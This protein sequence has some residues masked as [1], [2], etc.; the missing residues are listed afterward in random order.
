[1]DPRAAVALPPLMGFQAQTN[2]KQAK[3][4]RQQEKSG[5]TDLQSLQTLYQ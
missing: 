2:H 4:C 5:K 1:M 3:L